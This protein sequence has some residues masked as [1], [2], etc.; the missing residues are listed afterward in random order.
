MRV[1]AS[2]WP[3][4]ALLTGIAPG[5]AAGQ[6][7]RAV[8][9]VPADREVRED[10][11]EA[12]GIAVRDLQWFF[13]REMG[14]GRTFDTGPD[15]VQVVRSSR[16]SPWYGLHQPS[17]FNTFY[18]NVRSDV[19]ALLGRLPGS[20]HSGPD[21]WLLYVDAHPVCGQCGGCGGGRVAVVGRND[22]HG[23]VGE[24]YERICSDDYDTHSRCRWIGGL[25]HEL[26]HAAFSLPHPCDN[27]ATCDWSALM[28]TGYANYPRTH[29]LQS[30][31]QR[32]SQSPYLT[33]LPPLEPAAVCGPFTPGRPSDFAAAV[34]GGAVRFTW[35]V[36]PNAAAPERYWLEAGSVPGQRNLARIAISQPT[37]EFVASAPPGTYYVRLIATNRY[38]N[39]VASNEVVVRVGTP[40][41]PSGLVARLVGRVATISWSPAVEPV[42]GYLLEAGSTQG[43]A[44][45]ATLPV[46]GTSFVSPPLPPG[47]YWIRVRAYNATGLGAPSPDVL[48]DVPPPG[49]PNPPTQLTHQVHGRRVALTWTAPATGSASIGYLLE[50]G[51]RA[52]IADIAVFVLG[53]QPSFIAADVPPGSYFLRVRARGEGGDSS[54]SNEIRVDVR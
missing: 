28:Q 2:A 47:R 5:T 35:R 30:E 22:L 11:R 40:A 44:G 3:L 29:L 9:L 20:L 1:R 42:L 33:P 25:G 4:C 18:N 38:G 32:I 26:G 24:R 46:V 34:S 37:T 17:G 41:P 23:L 54:A 21:T 19:E 49:I 13:Q 43:S 7:V 15:V 12:I 48:I 45:L 53:I 8:Y 31:K 27:P 16:S 50:A 52:G 10:Y 39:S 36:D 14:D 51:S 6:I